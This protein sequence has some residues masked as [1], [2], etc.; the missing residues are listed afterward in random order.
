MKIRDIIPTRRTN[1]KTV[2]K[3]GQ[4]KDELQKDFHN[5]CGY[6]NDHDWLRTTY[7]EVDHFAPKKVLKNIS[8]T[9]YTNLVY[10]CRS[11][12]NAKRSKW[13]TG[14]EKVAN[15]GEKGFID[16][17]DSTYDQ[18][19]ERTSRGDIVGVTPLG[20]WM[21]DALNLRNP[22]HRCMYNMERLRIAIEALKGVS[23]EDEE[24]MSAI[25][26]LALEYFNYE[27]QLKGKPSF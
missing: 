11:C 23:N 1:P 19:F 20:K 8:E 5:R 12:N 13:P 17:C 15:D 9:D 7:Y 21:Y 25:G 4:H 18:Q 3:Y 27:E 10:S 16:P 6:C 26:K 24:T 14:D 2:A 22:S